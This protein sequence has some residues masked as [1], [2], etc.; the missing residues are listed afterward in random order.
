[1]RAL[2]TA[3]ARALQACAR[4]VTRLAVWVQ[5]GVR[6]KTGLPEVRRGMNEVIFDEYAARV[7]REIMELDLSDPSSDL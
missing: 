1:M 2:R 3:A 4:A 5:P 7:E 6:F